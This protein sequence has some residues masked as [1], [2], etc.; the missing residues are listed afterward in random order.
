M[1]EKELE[2]RE[3][4]LELREKELEL[5]KKQ[6]PFINTISEKNNLESS[7][8]TEPT[9][10]E[11]KN[12][13]QED[14]NE[15]LKQDLKTYSV[16]ELPT[17]WKNRYDLLPKKF[18]NT[19][20]TENGS[21]DIK[22]DDAGVEELIRGF[23]WSCGNNEKLDQLGE[24]ISIEIGYNNQNLTYKAGMVFFYYKYKI[25]NCNY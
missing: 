9:K 17:I 2:L 4:E 11:T 23:Y 19:V 18:K 14:L 24:Q 22:N 10:N 13:S 7:K 6:E 12:T 15:I 20:F 8:K 1:E 5:K 21:Y 16:S 25:S 3:K